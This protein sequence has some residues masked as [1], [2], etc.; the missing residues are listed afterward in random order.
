M[1]KNR[2]KILLV[3]DDRQVLGMLEDLFIDVYETLTATSGDESLV[4]V[5]QNRDIGFDIPNFFLMAPFV[6]QNR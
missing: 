1:T 3:D 2:P 5:K 4:L 6:K